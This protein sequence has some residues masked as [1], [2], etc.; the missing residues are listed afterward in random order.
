MIRGGA[1]LIQ[2]NIGAFLS[3]LTA[4]LLLR[5]SVGKKTAVWQFDKC[6]RR[7]FINFCPADCSH[8]FCLAE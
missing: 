6:R 7:E 3:L 8:V 2:A 5:H 4:V 1:A